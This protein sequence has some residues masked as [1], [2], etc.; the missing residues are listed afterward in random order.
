MWNFLCVMTLSFVGIFAGF[1]IPFTIG[2]TFDIP[3]FKDDLTGFSD[4]LCR[5]IISVFM[6]GLCL[7]AGLWF[8]IDMC[9]A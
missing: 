4:M 8:G 7:I 3:H 2:M 6:A 9:P 5:I 1:G